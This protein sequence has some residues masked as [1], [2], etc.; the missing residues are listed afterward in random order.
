M[1]DRNVELLNGRP[2]LRAFVV[3]PGRVYKSP[4]VT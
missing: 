4:H 1:S 3:S 2:H